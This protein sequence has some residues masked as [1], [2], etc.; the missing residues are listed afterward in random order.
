[1]IT[2]E[3]H[4]RG[5]IFDCDGTLA[6]TMPMHYLAWQE[7]VAQEGA[8]FPEPL[9]YELAGVPSDKIAEILNEKFGYTLD[10]QKIAIQKEEKFLEKLPTTQPIEVIVDIARTYKGKMPMAVATG[11]IPPI[12]LP[13]LKAIGLEDFFDAVV[14]AEDVVN[15]KPAPDVFLEAARRINIEPRYCQVFEDSDL[16]LEGAVKAGMVATDIRPWYN[17]HSN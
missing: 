4:I 17:R 13:I 3:P 2:I 1:M 16:G 7:T 8:V 6:D 5:L 11:G 9:F 14:T 15:G 10:P 12:T